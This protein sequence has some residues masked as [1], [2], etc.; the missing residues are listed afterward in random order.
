M[1]TNIARPKLLT[2]EDHEWPIDQSAEDL[3]QSLYRWWNTV[4][5][6]WWFTEKDRYFADLDIKALRAYI[7]ATAAE[8]AE[9]R[10]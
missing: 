6:A 8:N 9:A 4:D 7:A 5:T 3:L 10:S 2:V 1:T